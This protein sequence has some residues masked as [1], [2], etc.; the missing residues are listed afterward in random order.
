M[1]KSRCRILFQTMGN[2]GAD[3]I[4]LYKEANVKKLDGKIFQEYHKAI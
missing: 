2:L 3:G 1:L 4:K